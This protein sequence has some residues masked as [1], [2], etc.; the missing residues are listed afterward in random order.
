MK[1]QT[2][3]TNIDYCP[4]ELV[5]E[6]EQLGFPVHTCHEIDKHVVIFQ[7]ITLYEVQKWLRNV[8]GY[9][10][11]VLG[12]N[13]VGGPYYADIFTEDGLINRATAYDSYEEALCNGIKECVIFIKENN[14]LA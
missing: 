11:V 1:Q 14:S 12:E 3:L 8:K 7:S 4:Q 5:I 6:L 13:F 9:E 2:I 10:I